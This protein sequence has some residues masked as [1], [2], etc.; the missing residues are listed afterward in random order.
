MTIV[1][2]DLDE[3]ASYDKYPVMCLE[4]TMDPD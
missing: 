3:G 1:E 2:I 4:A